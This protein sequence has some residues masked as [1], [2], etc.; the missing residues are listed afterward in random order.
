M[1][2][3]S[4]ASRWFRGI[5]LAEGVSLVT[6]FA[7]AMPLKYAFGRPEAV[8][9]VGWIH[10]ILFLAYVVALLAAARAE[11]WR[12]TTVLA[13]FVASLVPFGPFAFHWWLDRRVP[14]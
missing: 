8:A 10:G 3:G 6:L 7:V 9:V 11:G 13:G 14:A 4:L 1:F 2:A 5:A 12:P